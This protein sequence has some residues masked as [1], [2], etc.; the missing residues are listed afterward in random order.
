M[1]IGDHVQF[2]TYWTH[3]TLSSWVSRNFNV[4]NHYGFQS[5]QTSHFMFCIMV[6]NSTR[7]LNVATDYSKFTFVDSIGLNWMFLYVH[8]LNLLRY[9]TC[10]SYEMINIFKSRPST[11]SSDFPLIQYESDDF[12]SHSPPPPLI[13]QLET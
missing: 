9:H 8:S 5:H 13:C 2:S 3:Q 6:R 7:L 1:T 12:S 11:F 4:S 10:D